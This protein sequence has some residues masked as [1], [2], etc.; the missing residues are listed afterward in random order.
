MEKSDVFGRKHLQ[1]CE[2]EG[3][4]GE[5]AQDHLPV[6]APVHHPY[7]ET[8]ASVMV[9]ACFSGSN[10]REGLYFLPKN[11]DERGEVPESVETST[12]ALHENPQEQ[13]VPPGWR[14]VPHLQAHDGKAEGDE[15]GV[16]GDGL[17][18]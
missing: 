14:P 13:L 11:N 17:A 1:D 18:G 9:W 12:F 5:E 15:E 16:P 2:I 6:Q 7:G 3:G 4:Q 8:P 10:G